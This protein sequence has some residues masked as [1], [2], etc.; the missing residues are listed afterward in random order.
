[1]GGA[2]V[3]SSDRQMQVD[4]KY[5][6]IHFKQQLIG[7]LEKMYV[8]I[9]DNLKIEIFSLLR[10]CAQVVSLLPLISVSIY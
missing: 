5:P 3:S 10:L 7:F 2:V 4:T 8:M 6:A 9:R 1:M